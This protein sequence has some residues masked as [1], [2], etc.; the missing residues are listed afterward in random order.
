MDAKTDTERVRREFLARFFHDVATPLSAV[1]LHL[2]GADRRARRGADPTESLAIARAELSKAFELFDCGRDILL[3]PGRPQETFPFDEFVEACVTGNGAGRP[4]VA[5]AT[6]GKIR[7]D[8][9]ALTQALVALI[10]NAIESSG[11]SAVSVVRER[12]AGRLR[13]RIEN[14][15]RLPVENAEA[16]FSPRAASAGKNWGMGLARAR[17]HAADAG[18]TVTLSQEGDRV[19]AILDLPEEPS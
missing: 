9:E 3:E 5:G 6:G 19:T 16:L 11:A 18:G 17:L 14:P 10:G 1:S 8:R 2:E 13:V 12:E 15:A 7:G 4:S